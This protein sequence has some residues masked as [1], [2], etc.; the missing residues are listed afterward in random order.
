MTLSDMAA[1][2]A[3]ATGKTYDL[4]DALG[5]YLA[6]TGNG[7]KSWHFRYYWLGRRKKMSFGTYPEVSLLEARALRDEARALV[8]KG[9]NPRT[10]RKQK[11]AAAKLAGENTFEAVYKQWFAHRE[12]SLKKGRQCTSSTLPRIFDKDVLPFLGR[13]SIYE[14]KRPDLLEVIARIERRKALSVAEKVRTWFNQMFR[15]ALVIL[16]DLEHNPA[17]DLDVV[18]VPLPPVNHNPFLRIPDLPKMLQRLR[19]YRGRLQTQLGLRFLLLTGV[20]TGELRLATPDQFHLDQGLWIIPPEIVKQLQTDMRRKRQK[21]QDIPPYIV[22]LSAQAIE[23]VR[24]LLDHFKPAQRYLF[25]HDYDLK[26]RMSENTLNA[27]LKRMGYRDLQTGHGLR[28]VI[29]TALNEIGYPLKW[30]D[31]QLSHVDPNKTSATYNHAEYIE[32]RRRM[33]Q[34]WADRLDL[35]ERGQVEAASAV[36]T[37]QLEQSPGLSGEDNVPAS[38][39]RLSAVQAPKAREST[40]SGIQH[41]RMIL[42]DILDAPHNLSVADYALLAGKSRRWITHEVTA[43]NLLSI[44]LGNR[45][46]RL[47]DWQLDPLKRQLTQT[48]LR[49]TPRGVD[50]WQ[51]YRALTRPHGLLGGLS[52]IEA[53]TPGNLTT[54]VRVVCSEACAGGRQAVATIPGG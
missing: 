8:A 5:L 46:Q 35:L 12:L 30:V 31:A 33:M 36:L 50:S 13:R 3:K 23:I 39:P 40:I 24:H 4:H 15:Y 6:V 51:I 28:A 19:K 17:S 48:V 38:A 54:A 34:D 52:P 2:R 29:S 16:P 11:R 41:E 18:A 22:P 42:L 25:R 44:G 9:I 27:A 21:P 20:R 1:R 10:H 49:Q 53:V 26:K 7:G 43:G 47:P 32:Q 37:V 45:G 14:I